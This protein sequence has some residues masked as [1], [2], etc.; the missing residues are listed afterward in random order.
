MERGGGTRVWMR[1]VQTG[2]QRSLTAARWQRSMTTAQQWRL[3]PT[4]NLVHVPEQPGKSPAK[5]LGVGH[6]HR[7]GDLSAHFAFGHRYTHFFYVLAAEAP[8]A[9]LAL[10]GEFCLAS[11]QDPS[12]CESIQFISGL[13]LRYGSEELLLSYG[14][15]DCEAKVASLPLSRVLQ[16]LSPVTPGLSNDTDR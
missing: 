10:S 8:H 1:G 14:V 3:S 4:A 12:D 13:A 15:N 6:I 9:P 5:L 11:A 2:Q 16:M 7:D